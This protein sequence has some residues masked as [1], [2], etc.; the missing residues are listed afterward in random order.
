MVKK[1]V[2]LCFLGITCSCSN[3]EYIR[4]D[5]NLVYQNKLNQTIIN[6][7][8]LDKKCNIKELEYSAIFYSSN[9][10]KVEFSG[11]LREQLLSEYHNMEEYYSKLNDG[12][13]Y[14][15]FNPN[16]SAQHL[17]Y[18]GRINL[19]KKVTSLMFLYKYDMG[20]NILYPVKISPLNKLLI[21]NFV[22]NKLC[23]VV[24]IS[25]QLEEEDFSN[26]GLLSRRFNHYLLSYNYFV[27]NNNEHYCHYSTYYVDDFGFIRFQW[28]PF[29]EIAQFFNDK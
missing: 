15:K 11:E 21:Y 28:F 16:N 26:S 14:Y 27:T 22:K 3:T 6:V 5:S 12:C 7:D 10:P 24:V 1:I 25:N 23:S 17:F 20:V 8:S 4:V 18:C 9:Q 29:K 13:D 2:G 19:N